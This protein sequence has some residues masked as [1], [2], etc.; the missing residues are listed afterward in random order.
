[1]NPE[2]VTADRW[3]LWI[4]VVDQGL[5]P[6]RARLDELRAERATVAAQL[7]RDHLVPALG[8]AYPSLLAAATPVDARVRREL[9][10]VAS[11]AIVGGARSPASISP[12]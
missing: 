3:R 8:A 1:M 4:E 12:R 7:W 11:A 6:E 10:T 9:R 5:V 2:R